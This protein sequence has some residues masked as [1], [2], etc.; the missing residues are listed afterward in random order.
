MQTHFRTL[1]E[2]RQHMKTHYEGKTS[3]NRESASEVLRISTATLHRLRQSD[4]ITATVQEVNGTSH[5]SYTLAE[6]TKLL[7]KRGV[8]K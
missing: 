4:A 8:K 6:V 3:F 2:A 1:T 5:I 7:Y